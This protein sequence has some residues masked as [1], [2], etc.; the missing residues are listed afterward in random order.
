LERFP[1]TIFV[2]ARGGE[3]RK[4]YEDMVKSMGIADSVKFVGDIQFAKMPLYLSSADIYV[5]TSISDSGIAAATAE[6]MASGLPV[7]ST[8]V[9]DIR[10]WLEDGKNG[11]IIQKGDVKSLAERIIYLL[12]DDQKRIAIG[13]EARHTIE[14]RQDYYKEMAKMENIYQELAKGARK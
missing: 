11:F 2:I 9:G 3:R 10:I 12:S 5:S 4:I 13:K 8:E 6:A 7:I 1:G 14:E